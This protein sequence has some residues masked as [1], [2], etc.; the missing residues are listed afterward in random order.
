MFNNYRFTAKHH[1]KRMY[2]YQGLTII[3]A[4]QSKIKNNSMMEEIL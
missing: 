4:F 1:F 3:G 2:H